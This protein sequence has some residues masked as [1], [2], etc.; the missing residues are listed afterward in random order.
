[1]SDSFVSHDIQVIL[2]EMLSS[3]LSQTPAQ[4]GLIGLVDEDFIN[5]T[6]VLVFK[7]DSL[8]IM[9]A[10][11]LGLDLIPHIRKDA[12]EPQIIEGS[13]ITSLL[14]LPDNCLW[15][16]VRL[17]EVAQ[18]HFVLLM[19]HLN[20][21]Q[22]LTN[23]DIQTLSELNAQYQDKLEQAFLYEDLQDA[24][25]AKNEFISFISHELKNPLTV[26]NSYADMMRKGMTGEVTKQQ[27]E[28]LATI[29]Q[30][31]KRMNKFIKDLSDQSHIETQTLQLVFESVSAKQVIVEVLQSYEAQ[32]NKKSLNLVKKIADDMP[33]MWCDRI[34]VIQILSNILSNAIKYTQERGTVEIGA[35]LSQNKWDHYGSA[36]VIHF[37]VRDT[38]YGISIKAQSRIFERFFRASDE[39]IQKAEGVGLGLLIAKSL[40]EMM[41]GKMWFE[42][43]IDKGS[44]FHF[45]VPI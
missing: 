42:S 36:E 32:I 8:T 14:N 26:I 28:Y 27:Q 38:G 10:G 29:I 45:T 40:S 3:A 19:L 43:A 44:T 1:L 9:P 25:K 2:E 35:E 15:H 24:I 12:F 39:R 13:A 41:G 22:E 6:S 34:R 37:W 16:F 17:S 7:T 21:P 5:L 30:N 20:S 33:D 4:R 18:E 11:N 23:Q 31:V